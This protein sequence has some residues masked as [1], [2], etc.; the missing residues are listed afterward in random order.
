MYIEDS[1]PCAFRSIIQTTGVKIKLA[2]LESSPT[3]DVQT[4]DAAQAGKQH[5]ADSIQGYGSSVPQSMS[6]TT[7]PDVSLSI[8]KHSDLKCL[9]WFV[10][11]IITPSLTSCSIDAAFA[12]RSFR[13]MLV[14]QQLS[15]LIVGPTC[16]VL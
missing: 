8:L 1:V 5:L 9:L 4:D 15:I 11:V 3:I 2:E 16:W 12:L 10:F 7:I 6:L 14:H 13:P